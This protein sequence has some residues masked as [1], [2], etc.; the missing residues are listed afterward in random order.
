MDWKEALKGLRTDDP[1]EETVDEVPAATTEA[2]PVSKQTEVLHVL[3]DRKG[4]KGKSATI[5]EG[6]T[7]SEDEVDRI[8]GLLKKKLGCGGSSRGGEILIQGE[9]VKEVATLLSD[10]GYKVK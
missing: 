4:R 5:V 10:M 1:V 9:R 7:I 3:I 8:A 2:D 6:F